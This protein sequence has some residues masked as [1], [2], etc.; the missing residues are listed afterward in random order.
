[1][2]RNIKQKAGQPRRGVP[3]SCNSPSSSLILTVASVRLTNLAETSLTEAAMTTLPHSRLALAAT[4]A[5]G[6]GLT[7]GLGMLSSAQ[8]FTFENQTTVNGNSSSNFNDPAQSRFSTGNNNGQTTIKQG[9]TTLQLGSQRS[10]TDQRYYPEQLFSPNRP[11][12]GR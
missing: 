5:A 8:A 12:D 9:N 7:L 1:L 6:L 11:G 3:R 4:L 2:S 10:L